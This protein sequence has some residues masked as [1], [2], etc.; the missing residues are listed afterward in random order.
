[1]TVRFRRKPKDAQPAG[2][3]LIECSPYRTTG[4][5]SIP[6]LTRR[7]AQFESPNE[8]AAIALLSLCHDVLHIESQ[9]R[10]AVYEV[11]GQARQ[12]TPDFLVHTTFDGPLYLELKSISS[13]RHEKTLNRCQQDAKALRQRGER[14]A[15]LVDAQ[16]RISPRAQWVAL[17]FR[18]ITGQP[19][20]TAHQS[21]MGLLANG[22]L[23]I[24]ELSEAGVSLIDIWTL[25]AQRHLCIQWDQP[26]DLGNTCVSLTNQ[27]FGGL[28]LEDILRSSRFGGFLAELALGR[29][30]TNQ[31]ILA[32][33]EAYRQ[34]R[35]P[36]SPWGV[37]GGFTNAAPLRDL[38]AE[39]FT[40]LALGRRQ[41]YAPGR[42][43]L[44]PVES[45]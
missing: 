6:H 31:H 45:E 29:R 13:F 25:V 14:L 22:P 28:R 40:P 39:E 42:R 38:R 10:I 33:A 37:V 27:P 36:P 18:Y 44:S 23:P 41:D 1:M 17:L 20:P 21:A 5:G 12:Y 19:S 7:D 2:R 43:T 35:S 32:D 11:D 24:S 26:L 30:P 3:V 8:K 15:F 4:G 34:F 16:L 9:P